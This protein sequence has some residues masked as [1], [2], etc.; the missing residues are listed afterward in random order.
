MRFYTLSCP[1]TSH[2]AKLTFLYF[3]VST[4]KPDGLTKDKSRKYAN[5]VASLMILTDAKLII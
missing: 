3:T 1:P 2:T 4:L 5:T